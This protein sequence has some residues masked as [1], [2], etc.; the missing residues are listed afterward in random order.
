MNRALP[1]VVLYL[2]FRNNDLKQLCHCYK[3]VS[4]QIIEWRGIKWRVDKCHC[5]ANKTN[6]HFIMLYIMWTDSTIYCFATM[7]KKRKSTNSS[8]QD[9]KTTNISKNTENTIKNESGNKKKKHRWKFIYFS[10]LKKWLN[11]NR[12]G[13]KSLVR[14][15]HIY[16]TEYKYCLLY[17]PFI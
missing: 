11:R 2:V 1:K 4:N 17:L 3:Y 13:H 8:Q 6:C 7:G 12:I 16:L 15:K 14:V 10:N 5:V 9:K